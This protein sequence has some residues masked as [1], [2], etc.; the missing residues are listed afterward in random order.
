MP[1]TTPEGESRS[2]AEQTLVGVPKTIGE[3]G[4]GHEQGKDMSR[5]KD[6]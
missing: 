3:Q 6:N 5:G 4:E 2:V 1:R